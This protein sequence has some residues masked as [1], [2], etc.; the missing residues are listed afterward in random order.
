MSKD[1]PSVL[2]ER[3]LEI[4]QLVA[5]GL[6]NKEIARR[7]FISTNT[8]KVH[9][10]NIFAKLEVNSRTEA[11]MVAVR[12]G[13]VVVD[14]PEEE[15]APG[16][17]VEALAAPRPEPVA[18]V[19]RWQRIF[20][21]VA[22]VIVAVALAWVW[23]PS[24]PA[25]EFAE[26][27]LADNPR[28]MA[29]TGP[30]SLPS[31]WREEVPFSI[32]RGRLA[33]VAANGFVYAI[34]G[35]SPGGITGAVEAYDPE[36]RTWALKATKPM[37]VANIA[38]AVLS[39][40]IY[41]PGGLTFAGRVTDVMEVYDLSADVWEQVASLPVPRAA[42]AL[43][44]YGEKLYLFGGTDGQQDVATV[45][46]YDP[47]TDEWQIGPS[48]PSARAFAGAATLS[49]QIYVA[50]GYADGHEL[51]ACQVYLPLTGEWGACAP[52]REGRGGF[53][54]VAVGRNLFAIGGG[55]E[56]YLAYNQQYDPA[57]DTWL[58]FETPISGQWRNAGAAAIGGKV[59]IVGGWR[60]EFLN[61]NLT[62]Q[63]MYKSFI[64]S[65]SR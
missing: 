42:Y 19:A 29:L 15:A 17:V 28:P 48:M 57:Q 36:Q 34:A 8:V 24:A 43:A 41:V 4:L 22:L 64:P 32:G 46:I 39:G 16:A 60:D 45:L 58:R 12:Q 5:Q 1:L 30:P 49:D 37:P 52:M 53:S 33:V 38:A 31:R 47:T 11:T 13:W 2:S 7:L 40:K 55:W 6:A 54:L 65:V 25:E 50:G 21:A 51:D 23:P 20:L 59:Y 9:L 27:P 26:N 62:Y 3:E 35:E 44:V 10:R 56:S 61:V 14:R 18:P 63:A